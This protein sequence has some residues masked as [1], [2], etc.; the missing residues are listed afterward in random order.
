MKIPYIDPKQLL[1]EGVVIGIV[2][3]ILIKLAS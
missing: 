1:L 3:T 2:A